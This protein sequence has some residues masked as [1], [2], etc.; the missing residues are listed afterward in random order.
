MFTGKIV[1]SLLFTYVYFG[2]GKEEVTN[3]NNR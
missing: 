3:K 1:T 2:F